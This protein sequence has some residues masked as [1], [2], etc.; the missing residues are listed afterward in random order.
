MNKVKVIICLMIFSSFVANASNNLLKNA[1]FESH[2]ID[3][4]SNILISEWLHGCNNPN[5][6]S[7]TTSYSVSGNQSLVLDANSCLRQSLTGVELNAIAGEHYSL[8]CWINHGYSTGPSAGDLTL[9]FN[10]NDNTVQQHVA[11]FPPEPADGL[12]IWQQVTLNEVGPGA[13]QL[14][15]ASLNINASSYVMVDN[16]VLSDKWGSDSISESH[17][18][19]RMWLDQFSTAAQ[20][21]VVD[22]IYDALELCPIVGYC[23]LLVDQLSLPETFYLERPKTKITGISGNKVTFP[24]ELNNDYYAYFSVETGASDVVIQ[25]LNFDGQSI[26]ENEAFAIMVSGESINNVLISNNHIHHIHASENAHGIAIYGEGVTEQTAISNVII[27]NNSIHDLKTGSSETIVVNGNVTG[28]EVIGNTINNIN[29]IAIDAIGGEGTAAAILGND[30]RYHIN[31]V[32]SARYG[33]IENNSVTSMSTVDNIQYGSEH[34]WAGAIY[35]DGGKYI[36]I[37]NNQVSDAEWAYDIGAENCVVVEHIT[38]ENNSATNSWFGD[39]RLGGYAQEGYLENTNINC[40]PQTSLDIDEGHGYVKNITVRNNNLS[41]VGTHPDYADNVVVEYRLRKSII[42]QN[43]YVEENP[44]GIVT[45]DQ[46][47]IRNQ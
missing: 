28:W 20:V 7:V 37:K 39:I 45:G 9:T 11:T 30:G 23:E 18:P 33:F 17:R 13:Q 25:N 44:D 2:I 41:S 3:P 4:Q 19:D 36:A 5:S 31:P 1:G 12:P 10:L 21:T 32:D 34:S 16:C 24:H 8:T 6:I 22:N 40:N 35:V 38:F 14:E 42:N 27:E 43:G 47:S 15:S 26:Q 46:N 29:N